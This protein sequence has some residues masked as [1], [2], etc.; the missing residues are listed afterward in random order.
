MKGLP[1]IKEAYGLSTPNFIPEF[2][3]QELDPRSAPA[4]QVVWDRGLLLVGISAESLSDRAQGS[5]LRLPCETALDD[6]PLCHG[7]RGDIAIGMC[8]RAVVHGMSI[9]SSIG[10]P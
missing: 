8:G 7:E 1:C 6:V 2:S 10:R 9:V 3:N 5:G 4:W